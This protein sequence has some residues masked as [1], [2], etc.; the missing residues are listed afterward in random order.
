ME[1]CNIESFVTEAFDYLNFLKEISKELSVNRYLLELVANGFVVYG[2][3]ATDFINNVDEWVRKNIIIFPELGF[4]HHTNQVI[5]TIDLIDQIVLID[6]KLVNDLSYII[7]IQKKYG[8]LIKYNSKKRGIDRTTTIAQ[9]FEYIED[10]FP[11][12]KDRY[13][14]LGSS[15]PIVSREIIMDPRTRRLIKVKISDIDQMIN[16]MGVL[17]GN[18]RDNIKDRK[19]LLMDFKFTKDMIDN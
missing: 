6:D 4:D 19:E 2:E 11:T 5:A 10:I 14:G 7:D 9:F 13:K 3:S 1:K 17:I 18:S 12:I 16:Q 8:L 15:D